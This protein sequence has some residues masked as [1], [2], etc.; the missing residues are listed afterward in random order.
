ME[1]NNSNNQMISTKDSDSIG[2]YPDHVTKKKTRF[3]TLIQRQNEHVWGRQTTKNTLLHVN[4]RWEGS[5]GG[6]WGA[7]VLLGGIRGG[8]WKLLGA[9]EGSLG[10]SDFTKN[11]EARREI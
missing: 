2:L 1:S 10:G 11:A 6:L 9:L 3:N 4:M 8:S 5:L 7:W